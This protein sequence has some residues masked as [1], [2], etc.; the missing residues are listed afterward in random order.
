MSNE[1]NEIVEA[2]TLWSIQVK[3]DATVWM[4]MG[5]HSAVAEDVLR[6]YDYRVEHFPE[7][8]VRLV[9]TEVIGIVEDVE[10]LREELRKNRSSTEEPVVQSE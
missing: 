2:S 1:S 7:E 3:V 8:P 4:Q 9:R 6:T 5:A 10:Q